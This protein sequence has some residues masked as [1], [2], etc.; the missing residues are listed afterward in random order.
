MPGGSGWDLRRMVAAHDGGSLVLTLNR[1]GSRNNPEHV[2]GLAPRSMINGRQPTRHVVWAGEI[3][4]HDRA[5][6]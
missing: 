3:V 6:P 2:A 1:I 4:F 5:A